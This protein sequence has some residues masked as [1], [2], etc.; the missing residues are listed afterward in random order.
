MRSGAAQQSPL[1]SPTRR[2]SIWRLGCPRD[3]PILQLQTVLR[4]PKSRFRPR[5]RMPL[6]GWPAAWPPALATRT[7]VAATSNLMNGYSI[8]SLPRFA[9]GRFLVS[10]SSWAVS[11]LQEQLGQI[12]ET[13]MKFSMHAQTFSRKQ[14]AVEDS[15]GLS[16]LNSTTPTPIRICIVRRL[17]NSLNDINAN[18][19]ITGNS[20]MT[21]GIG[22]FTNFAA[23]LEPCSWC[24]WGE[25]PDCGGSGSQMVCV[26]VDG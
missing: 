19:T 21:T 2:W 15:S 7:R 8:L 24:D 16:Y 6:C 10:P 13:R 22:A 1:D 11:F 18:A 9:R 25:C 12:G 23:Y 26:P 4:L 3:C 17:L 5:Y 14:W 20:I